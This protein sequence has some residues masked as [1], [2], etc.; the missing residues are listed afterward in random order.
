MKIKKL[1]LALRYV[2]AI[3][4][5]LASYYAVGDTL[6]CPTPNQTAYL[7]SSDGTTQL[8]TDIYRKNGDWTP[9]PALV[10]RG[11]DPDPCTIPYTWP[12]DADY[13]LV[14][15]RDLAANAFLHSA[16]RADG[17]TLINWLDGAPWSTHRFAMSGSSDTG[18][19][20]YLA[21]PGASWSLRGIAPSFATGDLLNYGLFNGGVLH[22]ETADLIG[23]PE[24]TPWKDYVALPTWNK[25]LITDSDAG[26]AHVVGLHRGGWFDVFGQGTLDSFS[27]LQTA[28]GLWAYGLQKVAIGPWLHGGSGGTPVGQLTFPNATDPKVQEYTSAWQ[29]GVYHNLWSAWNALQPVWVYHMGAPLGTEWKSYAIWP[30][31]AIEYPM[32]FATN[33]TLSSGTPPPPPNSGQVAL[34]SDPSNPCPTLGGTNNLISCVPELRPNGTCGS[35]DQSQIEARQTTPGDVVVFTSLGGNVSIVG[36]IHA[37]VWIQTD[38]PDVD[39]FVR[40]TDVYPDGRSMLMA[41][42]IQRARYRNGTCPAPLNLT[43]PTKVSVDMWSTALVIPADHKMRVI[44]SAQAGPS[45]GLRPPRYPLY[46]INP[47]NED[48]YIGAHPNRAGSINV[49]CGGAYASALYIP[50]PNPSATPPADRRPHTTPCPN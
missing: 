48:E 32:Y 8:Q 13:N 9:R 17:Q 25:Y 14:I 49:Y 7:L 36:R 46:S 26:S 2:M 28:G 11:W 1:S 38:L 24:G 21:A 50:V 4:F 15:Q 19:V 40:M 29:S 41:Q 3:A 27:R 47:Q 20:A 42:G 33:H 44:V 34:T 31:P 5:P 16:D 39:V 12:A 30:P 43:A 10:V 23:Y 18:I 45:I 22:R 6:T 35:Y 37:D